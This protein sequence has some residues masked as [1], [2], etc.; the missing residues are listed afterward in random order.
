MFN[1]HSHSTYHINCLCM[2]K[3][4]SNKIKLILCAIKCRADNPYPLTNNNC[5][6]DVQPTIAC[7]LEKLIFWIIF[8]AIND[9]CYKKKLKWKQTKKDWEKGREGENVAAKFNSSS[10][11]SKFPIL[12]RT[13]YKIIINFFFFFIISKFPCS[14][15]CKQFESTEFVHIS[16]VRL[17]HTLFNWTVVGYMRPK[18]YGIFIKK[19]KIGHNP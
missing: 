6:T 10:S 7:E 3:S 16:Y 13:Y 19:K 12:A 1:S 18:R 14:H 17:L 11:Y 8:K 2:E 5:C 4:K 9:Y 15:Y